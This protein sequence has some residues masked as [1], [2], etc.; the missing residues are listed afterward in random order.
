M[1]SPGGV[2][3]PIQ[4]SHRCVIASVQVDLTGEVVAAF[5]DDVLE[6]LR[7]SRAAGLVIDVSG[8]DAL[9]PEEFS[10][11]RRVTQ[12]A[13]LLG[14]RPIMS[15]FKPGVVSALMDL[16]IDI[17]DVEATRTTD[18]A[19]DLIQAW[20]DETQGA[21]GKP[22]RVIEGLDWDEADDSDPI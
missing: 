9:D 12:M 8:V 15:G 10:A 1:V 14:A 5:Q 20:S 11:L 22:R 17:S 7:D 6:L 4:V 13:R 3:I 16:D 18:D 19:I 21:Q 2:R